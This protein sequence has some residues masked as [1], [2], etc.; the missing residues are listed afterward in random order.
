MK[1]AIRF[2][3]IAAVLIVTAA[4]FVQGGKVGDY[5]EIESVGSIMCLSCMGIE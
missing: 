4:F 1:K 3:I 5:D 2:I